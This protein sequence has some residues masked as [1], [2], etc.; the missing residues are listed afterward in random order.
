[1]KNTEIHNGLDK[2]EIRDF[3]SKSLVNIFEE[4]CNNKKVV[5]PYARCGTEHEYPHMIEWSIKDCENDIEYHTKRLELL[6]KKSAIIQ[7]IRGNEWEECD[8]S[9]ET[10]NDTYKRLHM[11]FIG[12]KEEYN[13]FILDLTK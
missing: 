13:K 7:L 12:T 11:N 1:M 3:L 8:V 2:K 9:D 6:K 10:F 4:E 5:V